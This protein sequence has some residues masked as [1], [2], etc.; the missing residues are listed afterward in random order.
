M[1]EI[2]VI[3][4]ILTLTNHSPMLKKPF[5]AFRTYVEDCRK[6]FKSLWA[7][8]KYKHA[9]KGFVSIQNFVDL[10]IKNQTREVKTCLAL[11]VNNQVPFGEEISRASVFV[12]A[13]MSEDIEQV[14]DMLSGSIDQE[15]GD[16]QTFTL[17]TMIWFS[18]ISLYQDQLDEQLKENLID[19]AVKE[20]EAIFMIQTGVVNAFS[21]LWV[22]SAIDSAMKRQKKT[23]FVLSSDWKEKYVRERNAGAIYEWDTKETP[24]VYRKKLT[25]FNEKEDRWVLLSRE[26]VP[27]PSFRIEREGGESMNRWNN[28]FVAFRSLNYLL[29][30]KEEWAVREEDRVEKWQPVLR[31]NVLQ[32][33]LLI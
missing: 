1:C 30:D 20:C 29:M 5:Y 9:P 3:T 15:Y 18:P 10:F 17:F 12:N 4:S 21:D 26:D 24:Q 6:T 32:V 7:D 11:Q 13:S 33:I 25:K 16:G 19:Y 22:I 28:H 23:Y 14:V 27:K 31:A 8:A 2:D